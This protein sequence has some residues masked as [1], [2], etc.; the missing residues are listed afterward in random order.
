M[1]RTRGFTLIELIMTGLVVPLVVAAFLV[2][3]GDTRDLAASGNRRLEWAG[4]AH[5]SF[6]RVGRDCRAAATVSSRDGRLRCGEADWRVEDGVLRRGTEVVARD[7]VSFE[8]MVDGARLTLA[9]RF[10]R[11]VGAYPTRAAHEATVAL[12]RLRP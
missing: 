2:W 7:V 12:P 8:P 9:L 6:V 11:R 5:A 3:L 1:R 10:E 4:A